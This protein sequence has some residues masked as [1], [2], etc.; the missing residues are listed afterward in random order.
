MLFSLVDKSAVLCS[1]S[2]NRLRQRANLHPSE[3][4]LTGNGVLADVISQDE[5]TLQQGEPLIQSD[6]CPYQKRQMCTEGRHVKTYRRT[7]CEGGG[8]DWSDES[9]S[10]GMPSRICWQ[11][12]K[13]REK[14]ETDSPWSLQRE[15]GPI[16]TLN[17]DYQSTEHWENK[18]IIF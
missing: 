11:H 17:L 6:W 14:Q 4:V 13:L 16:N 1:G 8:R 2:L 3:C 15:Q 18:F 9:L 7:A 10:R 5:V 12:Q